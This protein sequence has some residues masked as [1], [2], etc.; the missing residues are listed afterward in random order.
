[1]AYAEALPRNFREL[2]AFLRAAAAR[3][4]AD[5]CLQIAGSLTY[6]TLLALVPL[7]TVAL[8]IVTAFPVFSEWTGQLD[9]WMVENVL[10]EA[11]GNAVASYLAQFSE[12]AA[13][14]TTVGIVVLGATALMLMLTIDRALNQIFRVTRPRPIVQRLLIYWAVLTLGPLLVGASVS[15]TSYLVGASLGYA[16]GVPI[17]GEALL[18]LAP[19]VLTIAA[20]T[21]LY[22][23][24][25]NR[26]VRI[27]HAL[28]GGAIAGILFELTK[29]G[30]A[31]YV[32]K[33]PTYALVY[34]TFAVIPIFLVWLYLS[35]LVVILGA[36][37]TALLPGYRF[38]HTRRNAP[39]RRFLEAL[40]VLG[41]LVAAQRR[42]A[43]VPLFRLAAEAKLAPES[44]ERLLERMAQLGWVARSVGERWILARDVR[45]LT[46]ADVHRE[47][48]F[49]P[50][51][52]G[53]LVERLNAGG[54]LAA[55]GAALQGALGVSVGEFFAPPAPREGETPQAAAPSVTPLHAVASDK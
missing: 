18:K 42:G 35:W 11:I 22:L 25:P 51:C 2:Y 12:K 41:K 17:L 36:T 16:R 31:L 7:I 37:I 27:R 3:F 24:V 10:P 29:R 5:R 40:D 28:I 19:L 39:G 50:D 43:T 6:T 14:L 32:A 55:H 30:F 49:D 4:A 13:R 33:I 21:L 44:C 47:F 34:G 46:L 45:E 54:L 52:D 23:V 53:E 26:R 9:E 15:M 48:V 38:L 8:S 20:A 1:M